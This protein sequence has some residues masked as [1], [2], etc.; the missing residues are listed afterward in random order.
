ML[1]WAKAYAG[2]SVDG[3]EIYYQGNPTGVFL[4]PFDPSN[5]IFIFPQIEVQAGLPANS[6]LFELQAK[7]ETRLSSLW[8]YLITK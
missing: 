5:G 4:V 8:P 6:F 1:A 2:I 3:V 7:C